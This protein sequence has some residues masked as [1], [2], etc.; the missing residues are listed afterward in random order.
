[1]KITLKRTPEQVELVKAMASRNRSVAYEAQ[2][3]LA[4]FIGPVLAEV[5]NQAP[6]VSNLFNS[7]QFDADDNPSI[8]LDLYY[9]I[10]DEDYVRVWSQ[11]HAGG[12]PSNQVLPTASELKLA[13]YTLD[14]AVDFDRR[15]AAKSRMDVVGKTFTRVA[16]E[17][18][19]KQER[20]SA[21]LLMTS[22]AGASIKTSPLFEDKQIFRTAVADTVLLD[23]FNKLMTLAKRI[24]TSW[25]GGTPTTR[26]RG[27]TDIVCS[28]E[29]VGSIRAMAYNPVNTTAALGEAA[30]AE[31]S[32]G[33][34]APEQLRSELYQNAGLDS[35]MGVNILEFNEMGKGQKFNTIFDTA[36]G[37]ATYKTFGG[38]RNAAFA[39]ASDEIIVGVDRTRDS[40]M[41][42]IAT[43]PDS[44]SEMNLIA[45]DQYS[46]R[47]NKIGYYG[48]IEEGRVVL[49]NRVL[50]G[51]IKG[52]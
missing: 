7:L 36:A 37:S 10:A 19:L 48:Q 1:M 50:L 2:V 22:L 44:N 24:N 4:E 29:V 38:A 28:P 16:Q 43:D 32:N 8:P 23:D 41:R 14:A 6:T 13:T 51:L 46:V 49:D 21:T 34:A 33:L 26:T 42:V 15:Y 31:N 52:Q 47:Q 39:G 35:F 40:L 17:I 27:I 11:S 30:A 12:L 3:A 20:T 45:D 25:I 9:D 5:L 18:L